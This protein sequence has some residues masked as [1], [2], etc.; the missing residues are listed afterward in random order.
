MSPSERGFWRLLEPSQQVVVSSL[1]DLI[2]GLLNIHANEEAATFEW[3][4]YSPDLL[5]LVLK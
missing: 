1:V 4:P 3:P 5:R 2:E